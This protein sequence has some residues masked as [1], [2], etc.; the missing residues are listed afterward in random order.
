MTAR[1]ANLVFVL[2]AFLAS[3][4]GTPAFAEDAENRVF[5]APSSIPANLIKGINADQAAFVA[6]LGRLIARD[7]SALLTLVDK[8]HAL[9]PSSVPQD[10]VALGKNRSYLAGREGL[11]LR[12]PAEAALERMAKAARADG[13]TLVASSA[14]RSYGYQKTVYERIVGELGQAAAD[15]ES[16]RPG[17]S[18][19][20]TG[21]AVDFGSI[22]DDFAE[23]KAGKW[24]L[25]NAGK[26]GWSLSFP[27]GYESVTGYRWECWHYR[28]I[29]VEAVAFQD[30][31]FGGV[32]QYMLE[33]ID[34]WKK[35][36]P[37]R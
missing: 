1:R 24:L 36:N 12:A 25:A 19:H 27:N 20:Q 26:Y 22:T 28:Y 7:R 9:S 33:F 18:Q 16:A 10:L 37:L 21:A 23:T 5:V 30:A 4:S 35:A 14:Y 34:A 3:L 32:Q 2:A 31:W 8:R 29:G 15:R 17:T 6:E 13:V 11:E